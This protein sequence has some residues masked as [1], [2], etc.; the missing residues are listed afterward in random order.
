MKKSKIRCLISV[1]QCPHSLNCALSPAMTRTVVTTAGQRT[2]W[3]LLR[4]SASSL[5]AW[6]RSTCPN[7]AT[8]ITAV[9]A[10]AS[11]TTAPPRRQASPTRCR[12][13][14][15]CALTLRRAASPSTTPTRCDLCGKATWTVPAPCARLS[16]SSVEG[17]CSCRSWWPIAMQIRLQSGG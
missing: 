12:P 6:G 7:T 8:T 11:E 17:P 16:A 15:A 14:S 9:R 3:T 10:T 1:C 2:L 5:W 4:R 13:G